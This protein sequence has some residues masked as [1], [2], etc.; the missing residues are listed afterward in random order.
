MSEETSE[1]QA[2]VWKAKFEASQQDLAAMQ[3]VNQQLSE[4]V[5]QVIES[6]VS[7]EFH[8]ARLQEMEEKIRAAESGVRASV[9]K[10]RRQADEAARER[11]AL[12]VKFASAEQRILEAQKAAK[13]ADAT[14]REA[15]KERDAAVARQK[16]LAGEK[17]RLAS[18]AEQKCVQV[19]NLEK[20]LLS[21]R[22]ASGSADVRVKWAQNKLRE[23]QE[24]HRESA[25]RLEEAQRQIR[26]LAQDR[27][28]L[29]QGQDSQTAAV[30]EAEQLRRQLAEAGAELRQAR[31]RLKLAEAER[32]CQEE[33]ASRGRESL[34]KATEECVRLKQRL[35]H[36]SEL[37]EQ[38]GQARRLA[39][40]L[41]R[42]LD[43]A[44]GVCKDQQAELE[45]LRSK[46][47]ELLE[48]TQKMSDKNAGLQAENLTLLNQQSADRAR[49]ESLEQEARSLREA[50]ARLQEQVE[51]LT[52]QQSEELHSLQE[53]L[54]QRAKIA[55]DLAVQ[56]EDE[57]NEAKTQRRKHTALV[58]DLMRQL[59]SAKK[60]L[61]SRDGIKEVSRASSN[62]SLEVTTGAGAA[63]PAS[64]VGEA[65][66]PASAQSQEANQPVAKAY[67]TSGVCTGAGANSAPRASNGPSPAADDASSI[68]D[69]GPSF[70][71]K[72]VE[73]DR[74]A[75]IEKIVRLQRDRSRRTEKI[76]FLNEHV[77]QLTEE[78]QK[79]HRLLQ[80][81]I[82]RE[83]SGSIAPEAFDVNKANLS[84]K[85]GIMAS[86]HTTQISDK[87]LTLEFSLE[88]NKKMQ[89]VL[90]DALLKNITLKENISTLGDEIARLST[91][92]YRLTSLVGGEKQQQQQ[93]Q[94]KQASAGGATASAD[95]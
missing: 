6:S 61:D 43:E 39:D 28:Q 22:E 48:F 1:Q 91:E 11:E 24:A 59:A 5:T 25:K 65:G 47:S 70:D 50:N 19:A 2:D 52:G 7:K 38:L 46:E 26:Q 88:I 89:S 40:D 27:D 41:K 81:Y 93:Q 42:Q 74:Q 33:A 29:R 60:K 54:A 75:L 37:E 10:L 14:A 63:A 18:Q 82:L 9:D 77:R 49:W 83:E 58:K 87:A 34:A 12:V 45:L 80:H 13:Q 30:K 17:D 16:L 94:Q 4:K 51:S 92:N 95:S 78:L 68:G 79:K 35:R 57:R 84:R 3:E 73:P 56:L 8:Q 69:L 85:G 15:Q 72:V 66:Q 62:S 76:D 64:A 71:I 32:I 36:L 67:A 86:L 23:E 90:E 53:R 44:N 21:L 20:E 31:E 55:E